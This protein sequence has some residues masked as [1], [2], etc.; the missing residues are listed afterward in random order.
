MVQG[1][2]GGLISLRFEC[3][4][5]GHCCERIIVDAIGISQ[6]LSLLSG[7][8]RLFA[9]FPDAILPHTAIRNPR[10]NKSRIK[11]INYQMVQEPCP[12]YDPVTKTCTQY[13]KRPAT[14]RAYPFSDRL[15]GSNP[16]EAT[17]GWSKAAK[18]EYGKTSVGRGTEQDTAAF[19][20]QAFFWALNQRMRRTGYTELL[21]FDAKLREWV[22]IAAEVEGAD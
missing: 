8:E 17:C 16:V 22:R 14:C 1:Y 18:I 3:L 20:I 21:F 10:K 7:E 19:E 4:R 5:C 9:A 13:D 2:G 6:G 12:L 11:I 15:D